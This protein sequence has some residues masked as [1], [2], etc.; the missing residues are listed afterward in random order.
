MLIS[1][2]VC[3]FDVANSPFK[4]HNYWC[5]HVAKWYFEEILL[6]MQKK[7]LMYLTSVVIGYLSTTVSFGHAADWS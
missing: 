2:G 3:H 6:D 5:C 4:C 7:N 1:K